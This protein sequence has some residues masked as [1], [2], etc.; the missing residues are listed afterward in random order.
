VS[1]AA[2]DPRA[3]RYVGGAPFGLPEPSPP[4]TG[5]AELELLVR[6]EHPAK[7]LAVKELPG[8]AFMTR[9]SQAA[10]YG[11]S[12]AELARIRGALEAATAAAASQLLTEPGVRD[13]VA[14]F[15]VPPGGTFV[16][17]G[18]SITDDLQSWAEILRH[19][20]A[21][22][23]PGEV[24][25]INAGISGD[26]TADALARLYGIAELRPELVIAMLGTNDCQRH[27][28]HEA[29]LV[30][31]DASLRNAHEITRWLSAAGAQVFWLTPPPVDGEAL[32]RSVGE[33]PFTIRAADVGRLSGALLTSDLTVAGVGSTLA[34]R[35]L[36]PD[37]VHP[38]L[39]G[40]TTI[41]RHA[42]TALT[43]AA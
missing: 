26:T 35:D 20:L 12:A 4:A 3:G 22:V 30:G 16:A 40:Q 21:A 33:R 7:F 9:E 27:G 41:A 39:T 18:D 34:A 11:V 38:S 37:G 19:C 43:T 36:L 13:A 29:L 14:A 28:P 32:A 31:P 6:F 42:L 25:V 1:A 23:R 15:P 10:L 5:A 2:Y 24:T 17:L 8:A